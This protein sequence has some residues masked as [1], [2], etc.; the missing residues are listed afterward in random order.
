MLNVSPLNIN[1][2]FKTSKQCTVL[3]QSCGYNGVG[4]NIFTYN[5]KIWFNSLNL[6][7]IAKKKNNKA[8]IAK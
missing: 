6:L 8:I 7:I 4:N 5:K 3:L 2:P 1:F